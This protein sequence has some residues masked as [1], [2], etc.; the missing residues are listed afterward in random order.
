ML[1][2]C[3]SPLAVT[4]MQALPNRL[5][6]HS[7]SLL[8]LAAEMAQEFDCPLCEI[9]TPLGEALAELAAVHQ[10]KFDGAHKQVM[11]A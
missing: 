5:Q 3:E 10:I 6:A 8:E 2:T 9:L 7:Y 1:A 11:L 4:L